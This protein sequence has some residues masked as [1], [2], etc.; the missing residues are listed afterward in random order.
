M[1]GENLIILGVDV[2]YVWIGECWCIGF[3][4][5][6][7]EVLVFWILCWIFVVFLDLC[8]WIKIFIWVVKLG[9]YL[10]VIVF[11]IVCVGDIIIVDYCFE[12]NVIVGF[13]FCV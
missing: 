7:L 3:D 8:Y 4:G 12:Y 5:L 6:V 10:W 9:V 2:M 13:V 11:G 1:F